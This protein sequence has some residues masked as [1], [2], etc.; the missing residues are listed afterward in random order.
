[1]NSLLESSLASIR[2]YAPSRKW[3]LPLLAFGA[4]LFVGGGIYSLSRLDI[5]FADIEFGPFAALLFLMGPLS[6]VYGAVSMMLTARAAGVPM[7]F[8]KSFRVS[9]IAQTAE[10]LPL[11]GG[12]MVRGAA[13]VNEGATV[14][15]STGIVLAN[16]LLW[17]SCA[18]FAAGL[19]IPSNGPIGWLFAAGGFVMA[20]LSVS[21]LT[22]VSGPRIAFL[23]LALRFAGL[24][25]MAVRMF[26][27]F[28][29]LSLPVAFVE[30]FVFSFAIIAGS[31]SSIAP[32][33][34]GISE[35]IAALMATTTQTLPAAAFVA[36]ALNRIVA[37]F[38]NASV[39]YAL[40]FS[41]QGRDAQNV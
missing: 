2:A 23:S 41:F 30:S 29:V 11:P 8:G 3:R 4:I 18:A 1:M 40:L 33:G 37:L 9:C 17:I 36:V 26:F 34:L 38:L 20:T 7:P 6:L 16:A 5:G 31:A 35:S 14:A 12:A 32:G 25:L 28:A 39:T 19:S 27:A 15:R 21:W 10:I 22:Y 13:L 24:G